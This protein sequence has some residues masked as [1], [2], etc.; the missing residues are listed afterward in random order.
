MD[1]ALHQCVS[2]THTI[3]LSMYGSARNAIPSKLRVNRT[4]DVDATESMINCSREG[5]KK[6][7]EEEVHNHLESAAFVTQ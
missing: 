7:H 2:R 3:A 1:R 4:M 5:Q 6:Y